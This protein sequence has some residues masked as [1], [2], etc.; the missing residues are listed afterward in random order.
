[1]TLA[2]SQWLSYSKTSQNHATTGDQAFNTW[3]YGDISYQTITESHYRK[4]HRNKIKTTQTHPRNTRKNS[5]HL[6]YLPAKHWMLENDSSCP[7]PSCLSLKDLTF[8]FF[9]LSMSHSLT[10]KVLSLYKPEK[11][12][13]REKLRLSLKVLGICILWKLLESCSWCCL[14]LEKN[15]FWVGRDKKFNCQSFQISYY[16]I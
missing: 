11:M 16:K 14:G 12:E 5:W 15:N 3:V 2:C 6:S 4:N 10:I 7:S 8:F 9:Y 13:H 1:M